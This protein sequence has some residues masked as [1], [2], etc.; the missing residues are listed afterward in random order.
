MF[1]NTKKI[2]N[3]DFAAIASGMLG[4]LRKHNP[5]VGKKK[6]KL[7]TGVIGFDP[8][9]TKAYYRYRTAFAKKKR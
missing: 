7:L 2:V 6:K 3:L 8:G 4:N 1:K 5:K 9:F